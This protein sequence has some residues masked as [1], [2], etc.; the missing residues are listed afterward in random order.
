ML[1]VFISRRNQLAFNEHVHCCIT[2]AVG[3]SLVLALQSGILRVLD[4]SL[5]ILI[6]FNKLFTS[7]DP[8]IHRCRTDSNNLTPL[9]V[10][11]REP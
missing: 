1:G 2:N 7:K 10:I 8:D 6:N 5:R 3:E 9:W 11:F 4:D